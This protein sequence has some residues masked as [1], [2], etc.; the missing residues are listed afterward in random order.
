MFTPYPS[1]LLEIKRIDSMNKNKIVNNKALIYIPRELETF[2]SA[3]T[4]RLSLS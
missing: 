3:N 2:S 4:A 1:G